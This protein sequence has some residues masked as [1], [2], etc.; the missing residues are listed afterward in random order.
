[1][2]IGA[3]RFQTRLSTHRGVVKGDFLSEF[4]RRGVADSLRL[5]AQGEHVIRRELEGLVEDALGQG[6]GTGRLLGQLGPPAARLV[7]K[8]AGRHEPV[9]EVVPSAL[10][11]GRA[12]HF[13]LVGS[14]EGI[15]GAWQTLFAWCAEQRLKLA[16]VNWEIYGEWNDDPA[17]LETSMHALL[18]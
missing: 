9:G 12:A 18:A 6:D 17:K 10:P 2:M 4:R 14:Y 3:A 15:P 7:Q 8:L 1:M 5:C 11:A 16:D 13:L